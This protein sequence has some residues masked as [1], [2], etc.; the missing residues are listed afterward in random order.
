MEVDCE[1]AGCIW[2]GRHTSRAGERCKVGRPTSED[3]R[4]TVRYL[5]WL[6]E[7]TERGYCEG[8]CH[9]WRCTQGNDPAIID[10]QVL[11]QACQLA[12][13]GIISSRLLDHGDLRA[14]LTKVKNLPYQNAIEALEFPP[15]G[16]ALLCILAIPKVAPKDYR[17]L[18]LLPTT[19]E[20]KQAWQ[21]RRNHRG[22]LP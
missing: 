10:S 9:R 13:S 14:I 6:L 3:K 11:T 19:L 1:L 12:K 7:A 4:W 17:V 8:Q 2:L 22:N 18:L 16:T 5:A 21:R 15:I 20:G